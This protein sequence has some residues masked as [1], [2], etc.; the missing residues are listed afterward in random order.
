MAKVLFLRFQ[1][2]SDIFPSDVSV[3]AKRRAAERSEQW[4]VIQKHFNFEY[5]KSFCGFLNFIYYWFWIGTLTFVRN[6]TLI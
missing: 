2:F 1:F 3:T 5:V 6:S 4:E